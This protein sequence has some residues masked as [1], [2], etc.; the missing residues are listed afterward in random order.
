MTSRQCFAFNAPLLAE[1]IATSTGTGLHQLAPAH[2]PGDCNS[3]CATLMTR[4]DD[5]LFQTPQSFACELPRYEA[6]RLR[7]WLTAIA[8]VEDGSPA[9]GMYEIKTSDYLGR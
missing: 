5:A 7:H 8:L 3:L 1:M 4:S 6:K 2:T 9:H